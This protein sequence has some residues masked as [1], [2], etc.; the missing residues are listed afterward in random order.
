MF[1]FD[2]AMVLRGLAAAA[3]AGLLEREPVIVA[4]LA[5]QLDRLVAADGLFVACV[6]TLADAALPQRWSTRR[7]PFLAKAAAGIMTASHSLPGIGAPIAAAAEATYAACLRWFADAPHDELHPLLYACEGI[8]SFPRHPA[9][10]TTLPAMRR[11]VAEMLHLAQADGALPET[12]SQRDRGP[13]RTDVLAQLLRVAALLCIHDP[14]DR[15]DQ[16]ALARLRHALVRRMQPDGAF[17]FALDGA[18]SPR[19]VWATMFSD[20]ALALAANPGL[21]AAARDDDPLLV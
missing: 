1:C 6:P 11:Y 5:R 16:V 9:F 4:G 3:K 21:A 12:R 20:Q 10:A 2:L 17:A 14:E 8:L 13:A 18:T 15:P 19:N 7:G